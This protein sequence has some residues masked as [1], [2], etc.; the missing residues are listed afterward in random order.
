MPLNPTAPAV[1]LHGPLGEALSGRSCAHLAILLRSLDEVPAAQA[2]FY[3]VG[4]RR[5]GWLLH[6]GLP[7]RA[8]EE[9][10][11]LTAAGLDVAGLEAEGRMLIEEWS[12]AEPP[13]TWAQRWTAVAQRAIARGF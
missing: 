8:D 1:D 12:I 7:G 6:H 9:R 10:A 13:E 11:A 2:S 5:N 4:A 3:A